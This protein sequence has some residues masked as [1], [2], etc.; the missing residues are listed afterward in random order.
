MQVS[1]CRRSLHDSHH[2]RAEQRLKNAKSSI[3]S[4][5]QVCQWDC[6]HKVDGIPQRDWTLLT[7]LLGQH[8]EEHRAR[9]ACRKSEGPYNDGFWMWRDAKA[10]IPQKWQVL[11]RERRRRQLAL[12]E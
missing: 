12:S 8:D 9:G 6:I 4:T 11:D 1:C 7:A 3:R 10:N 2:A 5:P